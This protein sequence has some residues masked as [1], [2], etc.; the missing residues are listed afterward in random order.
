TSQVVI[1][2]EARATIIGRVLDANGTPVPKATVR[3]PTPDGFTFVFANNAGI[4]NFPDLPLGDYLI[5][6]PGPPQ[7][8]LIEF[9]RR[10]GLDPATAFTSG[11]CPPTVCEPTPKPD[12]GDENAAL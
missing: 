1:T 12:F 11:D 5:E 9:M 8:G 2:L 7:D 10:L 3:L 6:A 4:F